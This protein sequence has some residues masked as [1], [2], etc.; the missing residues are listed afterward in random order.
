MTAFSLTVR[1][2][3]RSI[4]RPA[5]HLLYESTSRPGWAW[6]HVLQAYPEMPGVK[7]WIQDP[8]SAWIPFGPPTKGTPFDPETGLWDF[9]CGP[10]NESTAR[11]F[12][13]TILRPIS[14]RLDR[15]TLTAP[16]REPLAL[17]T[18]TTRTRNVE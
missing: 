17:L 1:A 12:A 7:E 3:V 13:E 11:Q 16:G 10:R 6:E 18:P 5:I 4:W 2:F 9:T 15:C 8:R 14:Q